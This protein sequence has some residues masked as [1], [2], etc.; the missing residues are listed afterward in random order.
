[1]DSTVIPQNGEGPRCAACALP[2]VILLILSAQPPA[3]PVAADQSNVAAAEVAMIETERATQ[4][5][6]RHVAVYRSGYI[7]VGESETCGAKE[8]RPARLRRISQSS[9][10]KL[11]RLLTE[12]K[13][14]SISSDISPTGVVTDE[15]V[16]SIVGRA[17]GQS[18][19]VRAMGLERARD[20]N[21]AQRFQRIWDAVDSLAER[22][23]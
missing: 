3:V 18:H 2:L 1:M 6:S 14:F 17:N 16:L 8:D 13:F 21:D 19:R 22:G 10:A 12:A 5:G 9:I 15:D 4:C 20:T 11:E 23:Y 7:H